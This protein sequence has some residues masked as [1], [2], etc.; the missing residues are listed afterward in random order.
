MLFLA[1]DHG[2]FV[3][4]NFVKKVLEELGEEF[5]DVGCHDESSCDY[6]DFAHVLAEKIQLEPGARGIAVCGTG[7]GISI[8]LNRSRGVRAARCRDVEDARLSR[9]HNDANVLVLAGRQTT[10]ATTR[11][12]VQV[13]LA[14]KF[15]GGRHMNRVEKI[16]VSHK[17]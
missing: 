3:L 16:E 11:E 15:E 5:V 9:L 6:P 17:S 13:F 7:I 10:E 1:S 8:A 2:G 4:K 14:T 12:M